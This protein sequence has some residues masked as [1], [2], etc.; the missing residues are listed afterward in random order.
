VDSRREELAVRYLRGD[1][2]E[3]GA[4]HRPLWSPKIAS[5]SYVD[6]LSRA[7]LLRA[8]SD[9]CG[10]FVVE[11]S[12]V[13]DGERL[14]KFAS[15]SVDFVIANHVLEHMEDPIGALHNWARVLRPNGIIFT[16]LPDARYT[17]DAGRPRTT[18][19]H[20][21][22]DHVE[23]PA[24][25]REEH[26][27]EWAHLI[28][29]VPEEKVP[30]RMAELARAERREHFHVWEL[31]TFL[32]LLRHLDLPTRLVVVQ[33]VANEFTAVLRKGHSRLDAVWPGTCP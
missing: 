22:R 8:W 18:I 26:Y 28:E 32:E 33:A 17:F 20:L 15:A 13:D 10:P 24:V 16:T 4:L 21:V 12:V 3:I 9:T 14:D 2:I 31:E 25:S 11:T 23:G 27:R 1:G 30:D 5:V 29:G 19:G 7:E 6:V